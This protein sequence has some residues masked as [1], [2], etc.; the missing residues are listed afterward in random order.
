MAKAKKTAPTIHGESKTF[1]LAAPITGVG[2]EPIAQITVREPLLS[3]R[4][5]A[6]RKHPSS[7]AE[8]AIFLI[9]RLTDISEQAAKRMKTRDAVRIRK[10]I[11]GLSVLENHDGGDRSG[12]RAFDLMVPVPTDDEPLERLTVREPDLE[13]AIAAEKFENETDQTAATIAL[14]ADT[15]IPVVKRMAV[16]DI[17][18]IEGWLRPFLTGEMTTD[19][20]DPDEINSPESEPA[21]AI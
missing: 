5:E 10:W 14:L 2:D 9:A 15:T 19:E 6:E 17:D 11:F 18:R 21:G 16:R 3:D 13:S 12:V 8:Q 20:D 1:K 7:P 4:G